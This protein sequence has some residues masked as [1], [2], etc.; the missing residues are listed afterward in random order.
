MKNPF[1]RSILL[2]TLLIS[3]FA[4]GTRKPHEIRP[5]RF[6]DVDRFDEIY[7]IVR[8]SLLLL[9]APCLFSVLLAF[10]RDP[11]T[12]LI[13]KAGWRI[14]KRKLLGNLSANVE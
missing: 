14:L 1:I 6:P 8:N 2:Y 13:A 7:Y 3:H 12:P 4:E 5:G 10:Y 9:V 11:A